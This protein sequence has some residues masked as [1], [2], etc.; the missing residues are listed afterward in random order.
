MGG[1]TAIFPSAGSSAL[2]ISSAVPDTHF[3]YPPSDTPI[4]LA[5]KGLRRGTV[6]SGHRVSVRSTWEASHAR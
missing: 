4:G 1:L 5:P 6:F 3:I 2:D